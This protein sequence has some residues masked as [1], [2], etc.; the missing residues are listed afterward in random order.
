MNFEAWKRQMGAPEPVEPQPKGQG[1]PCPDCG[2]PM[3]LVRKWAGRMTYLCPKYPDC[4]GLMSCHQDAPNYTPMGT[5]ADADTRKLRHQVHCA[6]DPWWPTIG[7]PPAGRRQRAYGLMAQA[8]GI[9]VEECHV[10]MFDADQCRAALKWL[11]E[12]AK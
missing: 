6:F 5:P 1:L 4:K 2:E 11:E 8:L 7:G 9:V 3:E 12:V 10:G